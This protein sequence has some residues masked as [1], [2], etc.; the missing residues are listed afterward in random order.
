M[1]TARRSRAEWE[2]LVREAESCGSIEQVARRHGVRPRTLTWWRWQLRRGTVARSATKAVQ[3]VPV[4]V[5][6]ASRPVDVVDDVVEVLVR[7]A[8]VRVRIGQDPHSI[9]ELAAALGERC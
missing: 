7:G 4:R 8:M 6:A 5:R 3:V 9:A 2:Q 1:A